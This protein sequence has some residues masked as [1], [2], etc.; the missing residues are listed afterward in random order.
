MPLDN[1]PS[2]VLAMICAYVDHK[3]TLRNMMLVNRRLYSAALVYIYASITLSNWDGLDFREDIP[4]MDDLELRVPRILAYPE[5]RMID[6]IVHLLLDDQIS[7]RVKSL[8]VLRLPGRK[9]LRQHTAPFGS[10]DL[11]P[12]MSPFWDAAYNDLALPV[13]SRW[14][15]T[16]IIHSRWM[17]ALCDEKLAFDDA[18]LALM[19]AVITRLECLT[20]QIPARAFSAD[21]TSI[22]FRQVP[23]PTITFNVIEIL[24]SAQ[25]PQAPAPL[26]SLTSLCISGDTTPSVRPGGENMDFYASIEYIFS[27]ASRLPNLKSLTMHKAVLSDIKTLPG[28]QAKCIRLELNACRFRADLSDLRNVLSACPPLR[29]LLFRPTSDWSCHHD[30]SPCAISPYIDRQKLFSTFQE[31]AGTLRNLVVEV[32]GQRWVPLPYYLS[33]QPLPIFGQVKRLSIDQPVLMSSPALT[34]DTVVQAF[35]SVK[36]IRITACYHEE[37][38]MQRVLRLISDREFPLLISVVLEFASGQGSG[39]SGWGETQVGR[40]PPVTE[41]SGRL[42]HV[43][44]Y[45]RYLALSEDLVAERDV[46]FRVADETEVGLV[47]LAKPDGRSLEP[48]LPTQLRMEEVKM[49]VWGATGDLGKKWR[50]LDIMNL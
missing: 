23:E 41:L 28:L 4:F 39:M 44:A 43:P 18:V 6:I 27:I 31:H 30:G 20:F 48:V 5:Q 24:L 29:T 40:L 36:E 16:K 35:P 32:Q 14:S 34:R 13:I 17:H 3:E 26:Q 7:S 49:E 50:Q 37:G 9:M 25:S 10:S 45:G 1:T 42:I 12:F 21:D 8:R 11:K 15:Q 2:E 19:L 38:A 22:R 47:M 33:P 46:Y